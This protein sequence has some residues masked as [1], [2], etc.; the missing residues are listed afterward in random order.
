MCRPFPKS[1][2]CKLGATAAVT[3]CTLWSLDI[4]GIL[5]K[6]CRS[7]IAVIDNASV[8][9]SAGWIQHAGARWWVMPG[10]CEVLVLIGC[11]AA[12]KYV[13]GKLV[14]QPGWNN[15]HLARFMWP[16]CCSA[17]VAGVLQ[18]GGI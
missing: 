5:V 2:I 1:Y 3:V 18:C 12:S 4:R 7:R 13:S 15:M 8:N 17:A 11:R 6:F 9:S 14:H 16:V 10:E